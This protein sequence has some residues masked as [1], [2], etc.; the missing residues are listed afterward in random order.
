MDIELILGGAVA[1]V[2][3]TLIVLRF[4]AP[5]TKTL[6]DDKAVEVL[7]RIEGV[8]NKKDQE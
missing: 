7:E 3:A 1:L 4:V 8:L 5:R 2:A 6:K